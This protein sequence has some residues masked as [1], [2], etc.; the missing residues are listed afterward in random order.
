MMK[1]FPV[2]LVVV[3]SIFST[4][5]FASSDARD[6]R[7]DHRIRRAANAEQIRL[8]NR[9]AEH[10]FFGSAMIR[11]TSS[12]FEIY[13]VQSCVDSRASFEGLAMQYKLTAEGPRNPRSVYTCLSKFR[14]TK[15]NGRWLQWTHVDT[16]CGLS[17]NQN[18]PR[19]G[20]PV[21]SPVD[22]NDGAGG[23]GGAGP[24]EI[25]DPDLSRR[26]PNY[27]SGPDDVYDGE[28][29]SGGSSLPGDGSGSGGDIYH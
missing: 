27:G 15:Q 8:A 11:K 6:L 5:A 10:A 29:G 24:D 17:R 16:D 4:G 21:D 23:T 28:S 1:Y 7:C 20:S 26:D 12:A 22:S 3:F 13:Q 14:R 25:Y 9:A 18:L 2:S 19:P